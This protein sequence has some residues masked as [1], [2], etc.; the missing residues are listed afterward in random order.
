MAGI[1]GDGNQLGT[2]SGKDNNEEIYRHSG[3]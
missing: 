3:H 1:G 2:P